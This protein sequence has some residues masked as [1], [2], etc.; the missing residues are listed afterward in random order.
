MSNIEIR[1][2]ILCESC[3][4]EVNNKISLIGVFPT[5]I[6]VQGFPVT[7]PLAAYLELGGL[8]D[9]AHKLEF[10]I[11]VPG[12]AAEGVA[13]I[14]SVAGPGIGPLPFPMAMLT[15]QESGDVTVEIRLDGGDWIVP[16]RRK[17]LTET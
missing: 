10:R 8:D 14:E 3:R 2:A 15:A 9:G 5:D 13:E 1:A 16:I 7:F 11:T 6:N 4:Q 17:V 12:S